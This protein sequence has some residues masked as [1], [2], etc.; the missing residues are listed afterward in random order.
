MAM[1][2][3]GKTPSFSGASGVCLKMKDG[4]KIL[5]MSSKVCSGVYGYVWHCDPTGT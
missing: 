5:T 1:A 2:G 3:A 4:C